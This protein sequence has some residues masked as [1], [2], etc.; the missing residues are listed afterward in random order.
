MV[1]SGLSVQAYIKTKIFDNSKF[2]SQKNSSKGWRKGP[3]Y[4]KSIKS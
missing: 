3:K 1:I 2:L 4:V